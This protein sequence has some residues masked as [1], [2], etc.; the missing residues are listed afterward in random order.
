MAQWMKDPAS[1][2]QWLGLCCGMGSIAGPGT[3]IC[4]EHS[5]PQ[6]DINEFSLMWTQEQIGEKKGMGEE[7]C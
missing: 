6:R 7:E 2:L 4:H 3:F 1:P 5:P